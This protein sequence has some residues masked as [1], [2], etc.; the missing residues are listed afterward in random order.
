MVEN[1][2]NTVEKTIS[3]P[4]PHVLEVSILSQLLKSS[5]FLCPMTEGPDQSQ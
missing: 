5:H 4:C 3:L 2:L 1:I